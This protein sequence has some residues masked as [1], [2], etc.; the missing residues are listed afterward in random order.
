MKTSRTSSGPSSPVSTRLHPR[1][2][3]V[4]PL[5]SMPSK[6][7]E[8]PKP[9]QELESLAENLLTIP[10]P[11]LLTWTTGQKHFVQQAGGA[12]SLLVM[13]NSPKMT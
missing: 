8:P 7:F 11:I 5:V 3:I 1:E 2:D 9:V 4:I 12:A 6:R 10:Q 13:G